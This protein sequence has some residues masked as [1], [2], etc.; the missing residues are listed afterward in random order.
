MSPH[1]TSSEEVET[2]T[3]ETWLALI[4][5]GLSVIILAQDF[6]S[7]NVALTS[8]ER[9]LNTDLT[10]GQWVI[11]VYSLVFGMLIVGGKTT[12]PSTPTTGSGNKN[13][14]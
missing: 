5:M 3:H 9:E 1:Q 13:G 8:I 4:A 6:S 14:S 11:N 2:I 10:T 7:V 12:K